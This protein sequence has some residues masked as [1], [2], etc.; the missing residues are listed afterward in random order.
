MAEIS[1]FNLIYA[2]ITLISHITQLLAKYNRI[3]CL[4]STHNSC[5]SASGRDEKAFLYTVMLKD[6][7]TGKGAPAAFMITPSESQYV[8]IVST[9]RSPH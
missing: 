2:E 5:Y 7:E 8:Y 3:A 6:R 9:N 1:E 4:D